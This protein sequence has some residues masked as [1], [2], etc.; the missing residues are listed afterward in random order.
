MLA[1]KEKYRDK[2]AFIVA[3]TTTPEG[4]DLAVEYDIYY[5]PAFFITN[6]KGQEVFNDVGLQSKGK[7]DNYLAKAVEAN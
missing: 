3:D 2:V 7:L 6:G 4:N 5:I 1:L